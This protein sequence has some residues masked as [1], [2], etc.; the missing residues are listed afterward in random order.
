MLSTTVF[1]LTGGTTGG[2]G[3]AGG[4]L[5]L[6]E[7]ADALWTAGATGTIATPAVLRDAAGAGV[8]F[9]RLVNTDG[10][11]GGA[12]TL[13]VGKACA[14]GFGLGAGTARGLVAALPGPPG[15]R[16]LP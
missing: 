3:G 10:A 13:P 8:P 2:L 6:V 16:S 9:V 15:L 12:A 11:G 5:V 7:I 14:F 4:V 1:T